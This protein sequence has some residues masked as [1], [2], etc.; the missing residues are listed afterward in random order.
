MCEYNGAA[1]KSGDGFPDMEVCNTCHCAGGM[2]ACTE[3]ACMYSEY[4]KT[5]HLSLETPAWDSGSIDF[6]L[7]LFPQCR[8]TAGVLIPCLNWA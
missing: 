4:N 3:M 7:A 6:I 2:V 5:M 1:Y 8:V